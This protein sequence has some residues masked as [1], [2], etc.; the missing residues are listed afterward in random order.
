MSQKLSKKI[1]ISTVDSEKKNEDIHPNFCLEMVADSKDS[2]VA[3]PPINGNRMK[4]Q[5][6]RFLQLVGLPAIND[7][8]MVVNYEH[9]SKEYSLWNSFYALPAMAIGIGYAFV[10]TLIPFHNLLLES[11]YWYEL[12]MLVTIYPLINSIEA[13][14]QSYYCFNTP[15]MVSLS[16]FLRIYIPSALLGFIPFCTGIVIWTKVYDYNL[17]LPFTPAV[18]NLGV[19]TYVMT[20][21][22]EISSKN[23]KS[24][25]RKRITWFLLSMVYLALVVFP[26]YQG[27]HSVKE[28]L[29][30]ELEWIMAIA[31]PML[32][33]FHLT[34]GERIIRRAKPSNFRIMN[35]QFHMGMKCYHELF[36]AL[37][38]IHLQISSLYAVLGVELIL[39][40][41]SCYQI[42]SINNSVG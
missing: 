8:D 42:L 30:F 16:T 34:V 41:Y 36:I 20:L 40:M 1:S 12:A 31:L 7:D 29:P 35:F 11:K 23:T 27:I 15:S 22:L 3:I 19:I 17:P 9:Q 37:H 13:I 21:W 38:L 26:S 39:H 24:G 28:K 25:D 10:M 33:S 4:Y 18:L 32:R 14:L 6:T 2:I 5:S